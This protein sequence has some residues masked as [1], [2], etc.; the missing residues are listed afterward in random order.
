MLN[1]VPAD[2]VVEVVG[3]TNRGVETVLYRSRG[4]VGPMRSPDGPA[5]CRHGDAPFGLCFA[6]QQSRRGTASRP[7]PVPCRLLNAR[8]LS[9]VPDNFYKSSLAAPWLEVAGGALF[10]VPEHGLGR[11]FSRMRHPCSRSLALLRPGA[12]AVPALTI[13]S[14]LVGCIKDKP[15]SPGAQRIHFAFNSRSKILLSAST[16]ARQSGRSHAGFLGCSQQ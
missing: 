15:S 8:P 14:T 6:P 7:S 3:C 12:L 4:R 13:S 2:P 16:A 10:S 9:R 1:H 11:A 5:D